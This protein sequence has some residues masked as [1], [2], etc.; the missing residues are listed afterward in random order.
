MA[1]L[2]L[3][4]VTKRFADGGGD[5]VAV[6]DVSADID[7][8]EFIVLVGPSGCGKS[9]TLRMIAG[10]E[11]VTEGTITLDDQAIND[12]QPADRDIAMVF[13]SYALYPHMTV[14][15]NMSFGLEESTDMPDDEIDERVES[16]A[17]M[18]GIDRLLDR[19]PG[20]LSGGQQQRVALGRAIVRDPAVF[21]MDEPLSNLDAKLRSQM[22]TELQRIQEDLG[23]TTVYVT[24]DQTEAMTMGDRIAILDDGRL[25][26]VATPLEAYHEPANQ[27]VAGFIGEP[28][29][30]FF[31][32]TVE[33]GRLVGDGFEYPLSEET[34]ESI[35]STDRVTLGV[36]PE[37]I[38]LVDTVESDHDFRTVVDVV[39]PV[40]SGNNVYLAFEDSEEASELDMD[41]SRTFVATIGGLRR[42]EAG[43]PAVA[44]IPED[45]I[46]L[47]DAETG[48][49]L[50]NRKLDDVETVEPQL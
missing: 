15:E 34:Q 38:E 13:Q 21:L 43:Q 16:A 44:R 17:G 23:V 1:E 33:N 22:R 8:G 48:D 37:D 46:H 41:E 12:R 31:E 45:A 11:S 10:L 32:T 26:Q 3:D 50:R 35:G 47:F 6:D 27:F 18:M 9:T 25:Q 2:T 36:R 28:S 29:M 5:I 4:H 24:H 19:K 30:N 20:E 7:D 14:R 49:A 42:V 40:G 39:E